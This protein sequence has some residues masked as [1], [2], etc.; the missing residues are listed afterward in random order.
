MR[1]LFAPGERALSQFGAFHELGPIPA[2]EWRAGLR[3]RLALDRCTIE[4]SALDR[5][6]ELGEDHPR[7]TMLLAQQ[8]H[9]IARSELRRRIDGAIVAAALAAAMRAER[10]KHEQTLERIRSISRYAQRL[11][12]RVATGE[13]LYE[14]IAPQNARRALKGLR[15]AG[16]VEATGRRG[17]W[18]VLDP[19]LRRYLAELPVFR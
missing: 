6:I 5:L 18:V 15:D 12:V 3:A 11:A 17:G 7:A 14:G 1:D 2:A 16:I 13:R 19:L 4:D 10:L 8:A 9:L